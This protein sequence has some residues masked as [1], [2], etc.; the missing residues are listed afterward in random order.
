M[1]GGFVDARMFDGR[2]P[3]LA[4]GVE[5]PRE[6]VHD[7]VVRLGRA[8]VQMMSAGWQPRKCASF[9]RASLSAALARPPI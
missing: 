3:D 9:S 7:G 2:N 6:V 4:L 1:F 8:V 5:R